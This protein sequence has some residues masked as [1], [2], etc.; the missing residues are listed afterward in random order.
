M[1]SRL[2]VQAAA[3]RP[4]VIFHSPAIQG[5]SQETCFVIDDRIPI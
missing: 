3:T 5:I 1:I 2:Y 4:K